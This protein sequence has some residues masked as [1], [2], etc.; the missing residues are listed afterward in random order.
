M[1]KILKWGAIALGAVIVLIVVLVVALNVTS[2]MHQ[3]RTYAI[4][5]DQLV[6]NAAGDLARGEHLVQ[7]GCVGCHA[8]DLGGQVML[9][10]FA[11][12]TLSSR[13][14]THGEGGLG[15]SGAP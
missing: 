7:V 10:D 5:P 12:G 15:I 1:R 8:S 6:L 2:I 9:N 13:N 3:R 4:A 11:M 14:L